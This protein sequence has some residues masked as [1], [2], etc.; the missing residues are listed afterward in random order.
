M[1]HKFQAT[2]HGQSLHAFLTNVKKKVTK[3]RHARVLN[4][5]YQYDTSFVIKVIFSL[6]KVIS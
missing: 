3:L 4:R 1:D 5:I 2:T 6:H